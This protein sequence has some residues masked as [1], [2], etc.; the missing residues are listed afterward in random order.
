MRRR[1]GGG[2]VCGGRGRHPLCKLSRAAQLDEQPFAR[3]QLD[4]LASLAR[5][6]LVEHNRKHRSARRELRLDHLVARRELVDEAR[7]RRREEHAADAAHHLATQHLGR[8]LGAAHV[9]ETGRVDLHVLHVNRAGADGH[10]HLHA[11]AARPLAIRSRE[12]EQVRPVLGQ[13][14]RVRA[15]I[16]EATRREHRVGHEQGL[17]SRLTVSAVRN[18]GDGPRGV[19]QQPARP[20]AA[21]QSQRAAAFELFHLLLQRIHKLRAHHAV[22]GAMRARVRVTAKLRHL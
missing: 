19:L 4:M 16:R 17:L 9:D 11:V 12:G 8:R 6:R 10:G 21:H 3:I 7:A 2:S 13:Q 22:G 18:A 14:R 5:S 1:R 15:V 20:A